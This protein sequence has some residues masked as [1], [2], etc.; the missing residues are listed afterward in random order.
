MQNIICIKTK[1]YYICKMNMEK[2]KHKLEKCIDERFGTSKSNGKNWKSITA[3]F[4]TVGDKF[5][6]TVAIDFWGD[7][8][9]RIKKIP[10]GTIIDVDYNVE[11]REYNGKY[12]TNA[13]AW[14]FSLDG[15]EANRQANVEA[16]KSVAP[17][18]DDDNKG[19]DFLGF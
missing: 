2:V 15:A 1:K 10:Q 9:E 6:R 12:Y 7:D 19:E 4:T 14:R 11:S 17:S 5:D 16:A 8:V 18:Q 13:K 3:V